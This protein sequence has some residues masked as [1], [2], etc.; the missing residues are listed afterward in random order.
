MRPMRALLLAVVLLLGGCS[1][2]NEPGPTSAQKPAAGSHGHDANILL[3]T[4]DTLR[5]D[6]LSCYGSK[7]VPTPNIDSLAARGVRFAQAFA[8]VP[9]TAPSHASILTGTYPQVHKVRDMGGFV[10]DTKIPT[11]ASVL[12]DAGFETAAF[13]GAAV[14]NRH[15]GMNRGFAEYSDSMKAEKRLE[16]LPGVVAEIRGEIVARRALDWLDLH[17]KKDGDF[18]RNRKFLLWTHYYDP[19]FPYDPPEPFRSRHPADKYG[20]EVAY[21]DAQVGKLFEGLKER[22]ILQNT[23]IVVMSDHGESLGE[24]GEFTHGVFLYDSTVHIPLIVAGPGIPEGRVVTQQV[25]SID[26]MP[27]IIEYLGL[28]PLE[29]VQGSSLVPSL[30][31]GKRVRT[32]YCYM[33]T[34]YP[35]TTM[36]WS[37]LRGM[38]TDE[39]KLIVAPKPE[40]YQLTEDSGE[41]NNLV[42]KRPAEA[43]HL[44][45]KVWEVAGSPQSLG[46]LKPQPLDE[47]RRRELQ[48]LGYVGAGS[49]TLRIDM[50]GPDPKDR[51]EVLAVL[52]QAA[53]AMNHDRFREAVPMLQRLVPRDPGN[54]MIYKHLAHCFQRLGRHERAEKVYLEAIKNKAD[55]DQ[56][57]AE[58]GGIYVRRGDLAR[59][60]ES[61]ERATKLNPSNLENMDNLVT[62]YLHLGRAGEAQRVLRA[63]LT[64]NERHA[65]AHNLFGI[66][67]VQSGRG[68]EARRHFEKA[69]ECD[70]DL[71]E[72]YMNLGLLAENAGETKSAIDY[73]KRFLKKASPEKYREVIPKVKAALADLQATNG[74]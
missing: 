5:A 18:G 12:A 19:H 52:K 68:P 73:Y 54:P 57:H 1:R 74:R 46:E 9:L 42:S 60:V 27:S 3:I 66:L 61:M 34:L 21:A 29:N 53:D 64:Q 69:V 24:H 43:D 58:L 22:G 38:R 8:Q 55:S 36:G 65:P 48:A 49:R 63:I 23:L 25:R 45:K 31:E 28:P 51:L 33:E 44:Q 67:E 41:S 39:W 15:Y 2:R 7:S 26:V 6:H 32:N 47:E 37:E 40:L 50:S 10:L 56:T 72:P 62:A 14:L 70:P 13:V 30:I 4:I 17:L 71:A 35:K 59:A 16:K 20:G 11:L